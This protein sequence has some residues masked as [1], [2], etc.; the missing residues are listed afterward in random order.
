MMNFCA[1]V[2]FVLVGGLLIPLAASADPVPEYVLQKDYENCM[3]GETAQ[4]DV[5]RAQYCSCVRNGMRNWDESTYAG[6]LVEQARTQQLP[7]PIEELA[8]ACI[9]KV[10]H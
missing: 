3:A 4:Q 6:L 7:A 1:L 5:Q 10:I 9:Q 8:K 2:T